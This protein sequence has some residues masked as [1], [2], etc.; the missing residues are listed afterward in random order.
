MSAPKSI[1]ELD[2]L[3]QTS[4]RKVRSTAPLGPPE[5]GRTGLLLVDP[6]HLLASLEVDPP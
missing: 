1:T 2:S 6:L 4:H 3:Q 5:K